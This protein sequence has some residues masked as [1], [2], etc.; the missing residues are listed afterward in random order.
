MDLDKYSIYSH[1]SYRSQEKEVLLGYCIFTGF[2]GYSLSRK[3]LIINNDTLMRVIVALL[4]ENNT[5]Q[6]DI[7]RQ[8][9]AP[10]LALSCI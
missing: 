5:T 1:C 10:C 6:E 3:F 4:W 2:R 9:K 8:Q 7:N